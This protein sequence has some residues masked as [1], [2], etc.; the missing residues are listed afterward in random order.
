MEQKKKQLIY[1]AVDYLQSLS[2]GT[3]TTVYE[4]IKAV[5]PEAFKRSDVWF[6]NDLP[7]EEM[8]L[9]MITVYIER[10]AGLRGLVLDSSKYDDMVTGLPFHIPFIK[11]CRNN[12]NT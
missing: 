12:K 9:F 2:N 1:D 5:R 4:A 11:R 8:E 7:L 3:E 10:L 6:D